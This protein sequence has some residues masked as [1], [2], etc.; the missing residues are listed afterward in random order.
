MPERKMKYFKQNRPEK[1]GGKRFAR[2]TY[3]V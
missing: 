3:I 1:G 2:M